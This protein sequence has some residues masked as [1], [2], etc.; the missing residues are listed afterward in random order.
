MIQRDRYKF[1]GA[2]LA[3]FLIFGYLAGCGSTNEPLTISSNANNPAPI[4]TA[5]VVPTPSPTVPLT[6]IPTPTTPATPSTPVPLADPNFV[7]AT[8]IGPGPGPNLQAVGTGNVVINYVLARAVPTAVST[9]EYSGFNQQGYLTYTENSPRQSQ[10]R[11]TGVPVNVVRLQ[12]DLISNGAL[13][14]RGTIP[15][16]VGSGLTTTIS[17]PAFQDVTGPP[18]DLSGRY[19]VNGIE[20]TATRPGFSRGEF[21]LDANGGVTSGALTLVSALGGQ[22][23]SFNVTGGNLT[24]QPDR[25]FTGTLIATPFNLTLTGQGSLSGALSA[26]A[27]GGTGMDQIAM[28]VYAQK[29]TTEISQASLNGNFVFAAAHTGI[30]AGFSN[31]TLQFDGA[32]KVTGGQL[33]HVDKGTQ[34]ILGGSYTTQANGAVSLSL[35][36]SPGGTLALAGS[37]GGAGILCVSGT[38]VTGENLFLLATR[39]PAQACDASDLGN[40]PRTVGL[41]CDQSVYVSDLQIDPQGSVSSGTV[42]LFDKS[43]N[44]PSLN[45]VLGG[46]FKFNSATSIAGSILVRPQ[47]A[48]YLTI[49]LNLSRGF[50]TSDKRMGVGTGSN[51][52]LVEP[53]KIRG[54]AIS[55][56]I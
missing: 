26:A 8:L 2:I 7:N 38:G 54:F 44:A 6:P 25:R 39:D 37:L 48:P 29:S 28:L 52:E 35:T 42:M 49:N 20:P 27:V 12:I 15:I 31:G 43:F 33:V 18:L 14:G 36:T 50:A 4:A 47:I 40:N 22:T 1:I 3:C 17:D 45:T 9:V 53:N 11:L 56:K 16:Q 32:G 51:G 34:T 19:F 5:T 41:V 10:V 46:T 30:G 13:V 24:M 23:L 21:T 55:N